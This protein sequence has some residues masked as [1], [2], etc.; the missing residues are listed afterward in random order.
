M[1]ERFLVFLNR[2]K[3][4]CFSANII[5]S[6][7]ITTPIRPL[8]EHDLRGGHIEEKH[9]NKDLLY[10]RN[11]LK[12]EPKIPVAS[13]FWNIKAGNIAI[14][15]LVMVKLEDIIKWLTTNT[16]KP[17][18]FYRAQLPINCRIGYSIRRRDGKLVYCRSVGLYLA[19]ITP[20]NFFILSAFPQ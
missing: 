12:N 4:N 18:K 13:S 7:S 2:C 11:R 1:I 15:Y 19:R 8:R 5:M 3:F 16:S 9:I 20:R 17:I 10:L 14:N 6:N